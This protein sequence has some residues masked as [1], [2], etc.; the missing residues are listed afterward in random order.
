[1]RLLLHW[2]FA[3]PIG[4]VLALVTGLVVLVVA[5]SSMPEVTAALAGGA[6]RALTSL[7]GEVA[8]PEELRL[9]V[10]AFSGVLG[11]ITILLAAP[12]LPFYVVLLVLAGPLVLVAGLSEIF[13]IRS[14]LAQVGFA[15]LLAVV[16][17]LAALGLS[18][19]PTAAEMKIM[20][21]TGAAGA[22][23]GFVYWALAGRRAGVPAR[24]EPVSASG[25]SGS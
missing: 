18:R 24:R 10:E 9:A 22:A 2:L 5:G 8:S 6:V 15:G 19:A 16:F 21:L 14:F 7:F 12:L 3:V 4:L 13:A 25:S 20:L 11:L 23:A 1:M 17:P